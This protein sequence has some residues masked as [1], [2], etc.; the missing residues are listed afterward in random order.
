[1]RP[2]EGFSSFIYLWS[3]LVPVQL[4]LRWAFFPCL[5][6]S[7][8]LRRVPCSL[9]CLQQMIH[10]TCFCQDETNYPLEKPSVL[11]IKE[12]WAE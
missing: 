2:D 8:L 10:L 3:K 9:E 12:N 6:V 1:M 4:F 11:G 5:S 7:Y